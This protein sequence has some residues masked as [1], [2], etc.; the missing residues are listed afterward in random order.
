MVGMLREE[1][2]SIPHIILVA[3]KLD[4][5]SH[6]EVQLDGARQWARDAGVGFMATSALQNVGVSELLEH[7]ARLT[8]M[9]IK[10]RLDEENSENNN[11]RNDNM[12]TL[13][14][15]PAAKSS[16]WFARLGSCFG[17]STNDVG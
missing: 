10:G 11:T 6:A 14:E 9:P 3:T 7:V 4:L 12:I 16:G 8:R 13:N 17:R 5:Q 1:L 15:A 2:E